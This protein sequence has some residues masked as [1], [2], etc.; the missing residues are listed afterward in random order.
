MNNSKLLL[1]AI[2]LALL[3]GCASTGPDDG[4]RARNLAEIEQAR[5]DGTFPITERN[6]V[7]PAWEQP[8]ARASAAP[9]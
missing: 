7:W 9:N 1:P 8:S 6:Y 2:A 3:A 4:I 5:K